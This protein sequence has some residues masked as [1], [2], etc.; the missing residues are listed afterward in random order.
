MH[1][2]EDDGLENKLDINLKTVYDILMAVEQ[3]RQYSNIATNNIIDKNKPTKPAFVREIVYGVLENKYLLD[4]KISRL[5]R[6]KIKDVRPQDLTILRSGIYQLEYMNSIKSYTV[7]NESV[8]IAK[9]FAKGRDKF[10]NAIL[11]RYAREG[12]NLNPVPKSEEISDIISFWKIKYSFETWILKLFVNQ[13]GLVETENILKS[14]NRHP[15]FFVRTNLNE[16]SR[17]ELQKKLK[18]MGIESVASERTDTALKL[19]GKN[20][21]ANSLYERGFY[22]VQDE[23]SQI[24]I[25]EMEIEKNL[26]VVDVCAAPGGKTFAIAERMKNTGMV[27]SRDIYMHKIKKIKNEAKRLRLSNVQASLWDGTKPEEDLVEKCHR[28]LCDVPCSGLGVIARKPEIKY[29][30]N[31]EKIKKLYEIQFEILRASAKYLKEEGILLYS[32]CTIN[33][34][35]NEAIVERFLKENIDFKLEK[36][37][38][39]LPNRDDT[40]GFFIAKIVKEA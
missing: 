12:K 39:L 11:Q 31:S 16:I 21:V 20:L 7:V 37:I 28:V 6:G 3:K 23:S 27:Y 19:F 8:K 1:S 9:K 29:R 10:V 38:L 22:S 14:L 17:D 25:K 35:E 5:I 15:N 32:T 2:C 40:D 30:K 4:Y 26:C 13:F 36:K 24:L 33:R 18:A 34:D